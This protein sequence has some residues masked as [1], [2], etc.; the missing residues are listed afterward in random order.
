MTATTAPPETTPTRDFTVAVLVVLNGQVL[1]HWHRKLGRW[2]PPGGHIEP[3]ELP[4]EAAVR[5]TLEETGIEISLVGERG[6]DRDR[7]DEPRQ[8]IR[9][10][11][12]QLEDISPGH[13]HIDLIYFAVPRSALA[14]MHGLPDGVGW[15]DEA[16]LASLPLTD[17]VRAWCHKALQTLADTTASSPR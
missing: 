11:G 4:D 12:I 17:E 15:Y 2:L 3:D 14:G 8:L 5:E 10:A 9:P 16:A 7:P 6:L 13:Q 1:L